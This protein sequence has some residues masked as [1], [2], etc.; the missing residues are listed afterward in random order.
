M[1]E[2]Q[3]DLQTAVDTLTAMISNRVAEYAKLKQDL[4]SFVEVIDTQ[5]SQYH[6]NLEHFVQGTVAWYYASASEYALH[7]RFFVR[8]AHR[9]GR[10]LPSIRGHK[11]RQFGSGAIPSNLAGVYLR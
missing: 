1:A 5:L 3:I 8:D 10:I 4:P 9:H 11:Y 6:K 2:R 7:E